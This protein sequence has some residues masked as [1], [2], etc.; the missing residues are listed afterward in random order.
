MRPSG[1]VPKTNTPKLNYITTSYRSS[2]TIATHNQSCPIG[3]LCKLAPRPTHAQPANMSTITKRRL[4][5]P[6]F[7]TTLSAVQGIHC[8]TA[9]ACGRKS[10]S[11]PFHFGTPL[12]SLPPLH[13]APVNSSLGN[14]RKH[15]SIG[16][17][18]SRPRTLFRF[19]KVPPTIQQTNLAKPQNSPDSIRSMSLLSASLPFPS[20]S[21]V[22]PAILSTPGS[23][24]TGA[25]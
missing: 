10:P 19:G 14:P 2:H 12:R 20:P 9:I 8:F 6:N 15:A 24:T 25:S 3:P 16:T 22:C 18:R 1:F 17:F 5:D 23:L 13:S 11:S 4:N 21:A 7:P